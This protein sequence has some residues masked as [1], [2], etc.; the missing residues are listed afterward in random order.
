MSGWAKKL[1]F[2]APKL[3]G[4]LHVILGGGG[5]RVE[6]VYPCMSYTYTYE[7]IHVHGSILL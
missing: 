5:W 7:H 2:C 1:T 3:F 4:D 6:E